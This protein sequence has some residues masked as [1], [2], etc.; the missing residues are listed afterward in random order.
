MS[1][2]SPTWDALRSCF[3]MNTWIAVL[4]SILFIS[5]SVNHHPIINSP[6]KNC[7]LKKIQ[8]DRNCNKKI[9]RDWFIENQIVLFLARATV[10]TSLYVLLR[11][12]V[13]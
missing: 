2:V 10:G 11:Q 7:K 5:F 6:Q 9:D 4:I 1:K 12:L 3:N 13:R 8:E